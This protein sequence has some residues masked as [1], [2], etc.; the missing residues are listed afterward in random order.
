[1]LEPFFF[2]FFEKVPCRAGTHR[3]C[4]DSRPTSSSDDSTAGTGGYS[5]RRNGILAARVTQIDGI[6]SD[7]REAIALCWTPKPFR[8]V[9]LCPASGRRVVVAL[10]VVVERVGDVAFAFV[11]SGHAVAALEPEGVGDGLGAFAFGV[12]AVGAVAEGA[13]DFGARVHE[14]DDIALRV[15]ERVVVPGRCALVDQ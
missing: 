1:M 12:L 8:Q 4:S 13:F 3:S 5:P 7:E 2:C 14:R 10:T 15:A 11:S 9:L 6:A